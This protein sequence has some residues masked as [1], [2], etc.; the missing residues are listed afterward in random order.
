MWTAS[1]TF[2]IGELHVGVRSYPA[3]LSDRVRAILAPHAVKGINAPA[4]YSIRL[5]GP[6]PRHKWSIPVYQLY[7]SQCLLLR[8]RKPDRALRALV[9]CLSGHSDPRK[10][11]VRVRQQAVVGSSAAM[12]MPHELHWRL[13]GLESGLRASG[14][15]IADGPFIEIDPVRAELVLAPPT[16]DVDTSALSAGSDRPRRYGRYPIKEWAIPRR[17]EDAVVTS[18][19][20]L[21]AI[22]PMVDR[23]SHGSG[24]MGAIVRTLSRTKLTQVRNEP[25]TRLFE[26]LA[27]AELSSARA[28]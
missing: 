24:T 27:G 22:M 19:Q 16:I 12:I 1:D 5:E 21:A 14:M 28:T 7:R 8:T 18:L 23:D 2:K 6:D 26:R 25:R 11:L 9:G 20:A 17:D 4:N 3:A 13:E 10:G 15:W